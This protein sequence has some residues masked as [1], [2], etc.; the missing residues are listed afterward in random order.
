MSAAAKNIVTE[1][2]KGD[3]LID[4]KY[5]IWSMKIKCVAKEQETLKALNVSIYK[6]FPKMVIHSNM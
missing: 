3:K 6:Y 1:H 5:K 2:N 4:N